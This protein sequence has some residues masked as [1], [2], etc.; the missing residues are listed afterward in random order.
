MEETIEGMTT[1]VLAVDTL[2]VVEAMEA[3]TTDARSLLATAADKADRQDTAAETQ[4]KNRDVPK[5]NATTT[6][7]AAAADPTTDPAEEMTRTMTAHQAAL[8]AT[9]ETQAPVAVTEATQG[10]M[11]ASSRLAH[12]TA[13]AMVAVLAAPTS[14]PALHSTLNPAAVAQVTPVSSAWLLV[15]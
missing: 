9:E 2:V 13:A 1:T 6:G 4:M 7:P 15:Y 5:L 3:E 10:P 11:E 12:P 14:S 8:A